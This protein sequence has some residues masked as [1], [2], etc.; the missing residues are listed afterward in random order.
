V[1][2][3]AGTTLVWPGTALDRLWV[4]NEPAY[5]QLAP[6]GTIVGP[7]FLLLSAAL[8][9][10]AAGWLKGRLWEWTLAVGMNRRLGYCEDQ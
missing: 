10:A 1:A 9:A 4:L 6:I 3:I 5:K 8:V 7:L 2:F